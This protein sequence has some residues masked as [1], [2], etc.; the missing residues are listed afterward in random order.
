MRIMTYNI[1]GG[2]GMDGAR[3]TERIAQVVL[4][5]D[6][7]LVCFQEVHQRLPWSG[8]IDQPR[9][10]GRLLKMPFVF[11]ANLNF[12]LAGYGVGIATRYPVTGVKRHRLPSVGEQRG[13][14]EVHLE[15]PTGRLT[16]F[17]THWGLKEEERSRQAE[18]LA[19]RIIAAPGPI[20]VCGDLNGRPFD[21]CVRTLL[22]RT[23]LQDADATADRP[24][25]LVGAPSARIDYI[26]YSSAFAL[27]SIEV[28]DTTASDHYPLLAEFDPSSAAKTRH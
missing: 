21:P 25:F 16:V 28:I 6:P 14:L 17:C 9:Q 19:E 26:F 12:G 7:H 2:L 10:L 13:A 20:L 27:Q 24:T 8:L 23:G 3:S 4:E 11:Q 18:T 15:A 1:R 5:R 22:E